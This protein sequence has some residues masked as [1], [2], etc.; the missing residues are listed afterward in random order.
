M[1]EPVTVVSA[2]CPIIAECMQP[3]PAQRLARRLPG[4]ARHHA[5]AISFGSM[6][7]AHASQDAHL[8]AASTRSPSHP[9]FQGFGPA[10]RDLHLDKTK[11]LT[12]SLPRLP[13][14]DGLDGNR[15]SGLKT[16]RLRKFNH[17]KTSKDR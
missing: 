3:P 5:R 12:K 10:Q 6:S 8:R 7:Q 15:N 14:P 1:P 11:H 4:E 2:T 17:D 9:T 13:C 16:D